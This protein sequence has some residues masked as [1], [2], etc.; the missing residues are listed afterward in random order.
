MVNLSE[1]I[2][3]AGLEVRNRIVM[4]PMVRN[5]ATQD[6]KVTDAL[7]K[8]YEDRSMGGVGLIIVEAAAI[9]W[10]H[11]IM[12]KNVGIHDDSLIPGLSKL[13][14]GI[15]AHGARSFIQINHAGPK[16]HSAKRFVGPSAV[17]VMKNK[18]PEE[19]SIDEIEQIKDMFVDAT[20]RAQAAG[21]DGVEVHGAHFYL[22]SAFLSSY[23]NKRDD[24][25][26]GS[27]E[28]KAR[29]AVD[30]IKKIREELGDYPLIF[31]MN[32][33]ENVID[34]ID[35]AEGI[36]IAKIVEK[37][38][39]DALHVSCVVDATY[40]P[41][42][43]PIFSEET[44]P[45]FLKG[46]PYDCCIPCAKEIMPHVRVPVIGVGMV[47]NAAY[48]R[49]VMMDDPCDLLGVGRALL[50]DPEFANKT[51]NGQDDQIIPWK[52]P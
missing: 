14:E 15:N 5:L 45:E 9:S 19:L 52:D 47:R 16:S 7:V 10:S 3:I 40:N 27:I 6:G 51:L 29:F 12:T 48:A 21:F 20:R 37:A 18:I 8:H 31:R 44:M 39:I 34:G 28:N 2:E 36:K 25:Y 32:G 11:G 17:P 42:M 13:A 46:Y 49:E 43:T 33:F 24:E 38:G 4:P 23:T 41:G 50:A 26:G 1:S 30:V 35:I 22:L